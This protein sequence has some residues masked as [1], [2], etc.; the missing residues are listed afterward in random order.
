MPTRWGRVTFDLA[1]QQDSKALIGNVE[2]SGPS[3]PKEVHFKLRLPKNMSLQR[4]TVNGQSAAIG[5]IHQDIVIIST[6]GKQA[7]HVSA[8]IG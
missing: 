5:G 1:V 3:L 6:A 4:V 8:Q 2:L 7:F